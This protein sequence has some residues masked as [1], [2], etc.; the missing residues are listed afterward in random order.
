MTPSNGHR[1]GQRGQALA[2]FALALTGV[3]VAT[4]LV[5]DGGLAFMN[6]RDAQNAADLGALA[7][8]QVV[9][10]YHI[11]GG[12][13]GSDVWSAID[14][15]V[16]DNGC[17]GEGV[18]CA[19][20]AVYTK[21][22]GGT[23]VTLGPVMTGAAIPADAQGVRVVIDRSPPTFF[24]PLIG[25]DDWD[26][27][28]RATAM[29]ASVGIL[30]GNILLPIGVDP[31]PPNLTPRKFLPGVNYLFSLGKDGPG[32]F[33]WLTWYGPNQAGEL[34]YNI[35][36]PSNPPIDLTDGLED[37]IEGDVGKTNSSEVRAC[38]D[39]W[40]GQT[41]LLPLWD[42]A[43]SNGNGFTFRISGFAR[44]ILIGY[45]ANPSID[46]IRGQFVEYGP[47]NVGGNY[48]GPPCD[49]ADGGSCTN[50]SFFLGLIS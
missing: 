35:C 33:S 43:N 8:T 11:D 36:N 17:K 7:G 18:P 2:L 24:L 40:I 29:T 3:L 48:G 10:R 27:E 47:M 22:A 30:P 12:V 42:R 50:Q 25:Q 39:K 14:S 16:H 1:H 31:I 9:A 45:D 20:E 19:W 28:T 23:Q 13:G 34:A 21:P 46:N 5:L 37:L 38:L 44:F 41:V 15:T 4:G 6:R 32:N 26:I 49:P